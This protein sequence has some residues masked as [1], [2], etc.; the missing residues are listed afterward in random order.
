VIYIDIDSV[1]YPT[2]L[3]LEVTK[4]CNFACIM[5]HKGQSIMHGNEFTRD[6]LSDIARTQIRP[7]FPY[8]KKAMLFGDG[9]PMIYRYFWDIVKEIRE[10]SPNCAID[11]INNG[12]MMYDQNIENVFS[13]KISHIGLSIGGATEKTHNYCRPPGM[14]D[15]IFQN[16][17]TLNSEKIKRQ[18]KEP[19]V[20]M[21]MVVILDHQRLHLTLLDL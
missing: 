16:Y 2:I 1:F 7:M 14:F 13:H 3:Q 10:V 5:C 4:N 17:Q 6:D 8:L 15:K 9:E 12:S 11:F 19:Y 20:T 21:L 18:T